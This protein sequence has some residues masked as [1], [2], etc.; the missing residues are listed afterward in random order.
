M[1]LHGAAE[2]RRGRLAGRRQLERGAAIGGKGLLRRF[3]SFFH[4][5]FE[6]EK[7]VALPAERRAPFEDVGERRAV[8][9]LQLRES[10]EPFGDER[11]ARG[12]RLEALQIA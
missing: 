3:L 9:S 1:R 4:G 5:A 6:I 7:L 10:V 11:G 2:A 8:F 12:I